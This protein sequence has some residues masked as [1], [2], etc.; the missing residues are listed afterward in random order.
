M[1]ISDIYYALLR[2]S[3]VILCNEHEYNDPIEIS[4]LIEKYNVKFIYCVPSRFKNYLALNEF[5]KSLK[6]VKCILLGGEKIDIDTLKILQKHTDIK[7]YNGYG[8]TETVAMCS[9]NCIDLNKIDLNADKEIIKS[10]GKTLCNYEVYIL[11]KFMK[12]VPIGVEGEIYIGGA[13]VGKG[14]LNNIELTNKKFIE[15]P[16][17]PLLKHSNKIYSTGDLGKW[18]EDGQ[19]IY[20]GRSDFQ[21]KINGQRIE[22]SEIENTI[23]LYPDI[24]YVVVIHTKDTIKNNQYLI[25]YYKTKENKNIDSIEDE[26][27]KFA[28]SKLPSYMV[29]NFYYQLEELPL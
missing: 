18:T 29:P 12:P 11:D 26:I 8:P 17:K 15:S 1:S 2:N 19:I 28:S 3:K 6:H 16:F 25:C 10:I 27:K 22:L 13:G 20:I 9:A 14:Y 23:K 21:V 24:D 4:K 5:L 7:V